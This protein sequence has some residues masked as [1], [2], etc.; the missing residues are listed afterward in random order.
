MLGGSNPSSS[1]RCVKSLAC[2]SSLR[3]S[4]SF[5]PVAWLCKIHLGGY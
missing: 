2:P 3:G 1:R 5:D 4:P